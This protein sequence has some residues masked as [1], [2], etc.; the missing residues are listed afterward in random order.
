MV[1]VWA[2]LW[3][4]AERGDAHL[5]PCQTRV[6]V[7]FQSEL[8]TEQSLEFERTRETLFSPKC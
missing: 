7:G 3:S 1:K 6:I 8:F 5:S 4:T 2:E